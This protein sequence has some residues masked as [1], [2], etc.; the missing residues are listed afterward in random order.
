MKRI[1]VRLGDN[2][3]SNVLM[4]FADLLLS[5]H[6][7]DPEKIEAMTIEDIRILFKNT[8]RTLYILYQQRTDMDRDMEEDLDHTEGYL[9]ACID[10]I[11]HLKDIS[12][13]DQNVLYTLSEYQRI[14]TTVRRTKEQEQRMQDALGILRGPKSM[15]FV[16]LFD[17]RVF[18]DD[19]VD[20]IISLKPRL[21]DSDGVYIDFFLDKVK[22]KQEIPSFQCYFIM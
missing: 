15:E 21:L 5:A 20:K 18:F 22:E 4:G 12:T 17:E 9:Q 1:L 11:I 2:D 7:H 14:R 3:Y 8:C 13:T 16:S 6:R 10:P 19:D